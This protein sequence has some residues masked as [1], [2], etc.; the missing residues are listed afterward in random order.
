MNINKNNI[1]FLFKASNGRRNDEYTYEE[2]VNSPWEL[3]EEITSKYSAF[4]R[5]QKM[6]VLHP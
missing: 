4:R 3:M 2:F 1:K 5:F 6:G